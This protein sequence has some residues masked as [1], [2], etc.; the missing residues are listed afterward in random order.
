VNNLSSLLFLGNEDECQNSLRI[1]ERTKKPA[2][3]A[4]KRNKKPVVESFDEE[5]VDDEQDD[6]GS[7]AES[8]GDKEN[9]LRSV[10][11]F[12]NVEESEDERSNLRTEGL[13]MITTNTLPMN[14][15]SKLLGR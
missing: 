1:I 7:D 6:R 15:P 4:A 12:N 10:D 9:Q 13:T 11:D 14:Q 3:P 2:P 8:E 5:E